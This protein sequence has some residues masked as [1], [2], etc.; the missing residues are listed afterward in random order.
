MQHSAAGRASARPSVRRL[1]SVRA[2]VLRFQLLTCLTAFPC[3]LHRFIFTLISL[4]FYLSF[5][6]FQNISKSQCAQPLHYQ[7]FYFLIEKV[8][9]YFLISIYLFVVAS[10]LSCGTFCCHVRTSFQPWSMGSRGRAQL[11]RGV[12]DLSSLARDQT[13]IPCIGRWILNHWTTRE[14]P[15]LSIFIYTFENKF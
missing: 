14:S 3:W 9:L 6:I 8:M 5:L 7:S 10:G 12:Q 13:S 15:I 11:P 2:F 4:L 1:A